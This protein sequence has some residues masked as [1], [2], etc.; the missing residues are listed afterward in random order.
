M[1]N[2]GVQFQKVNASDSLLD[3]LNAQTFVVKD[4]VYPNL[5]WNLLA[6]QIYR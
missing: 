4:K 3:T 6:K 1:V 2:G 5:K